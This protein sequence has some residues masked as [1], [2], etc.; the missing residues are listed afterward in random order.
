MLTGRGLSAQASL[1]Q[2][3]ASRARIV[4]SL[5]GTIDGLRAAGDVEGRLK[6][7]LVAT[8]EQLASTRAALE[9]AG[10]RASDRHRCVT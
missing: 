4:E 1:A 7:E 3:K 8:H 9:A 5:R 10:G 6:A 2:E